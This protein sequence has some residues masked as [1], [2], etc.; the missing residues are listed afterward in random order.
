MINLMSRLN[1]KY[2]QIFYAI[3]LFFIFILS[4]NTS[5]SQVLQHHVIV[6][7]LNVKIIDNHSPS[8]AEIEFFGAFR[9]VANSCVI[10]YVPCFPPVK[11]VYLTPD[12]KLDNAGKNETYHFSTPDKSM[13]VFVEEGGSFNIGSFAYDRHGSRYGNAW[14][15]CDS[16]N[17]FCRRDGYAYWDLPSTLGDYQLR[18]LVYGWDTEPNNR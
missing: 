1:G 9:N 4:V 12:S 7:F 13:R 10:E 15:T 11:N 18:I 14:L 8:N 17:N 2:Y 6:E 16:E 3:G 5:Y